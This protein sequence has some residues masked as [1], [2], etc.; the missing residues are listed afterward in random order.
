MEPDFD[1][2]NLEVQITASTSKCQAKVCSCHS[3]QNWHSE[4]TRARIGCVAS[5]S[6]TGCELQVL[7]TPN[8]MWNINHLL[9]RELWM[10]MGI[11]KPTMNDYSWLLTI[12]EDAAVQ[13]ASLCYTS[14][15]DLGL[16]NATSE[17]DN[18]NGLL[19]QTSGT[20]APSSLSLSKSSKE[21]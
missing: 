13:Y 11:I 2:R 4:A 19:W 12:N 14:W 6:V 18:P 7:F 3:G 20:R 21:E 10:I 17:F 8:Y 15:H 16:A 1:P 9:L 5:P